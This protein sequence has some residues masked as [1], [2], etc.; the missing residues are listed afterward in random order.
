ML[1]TVVDDVAISGVL[2]AVFAI[3][4]QPI[5]AW[6]FV[7]AMRAAGI[8]VNPYTTDPKKLFPAADAET[9]R[10]SAS[11]ATSTSSSVRPRKGDSRV[12]GGGTGARVDRRRRGAHAIG[13]F[14]PCAPAQ[15]GARC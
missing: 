1:E 4:L 6:G 12:A 10:D 3:I 8:L 9:E 5:C 2:A 14:R 15:P 13:W 11:I 7:R